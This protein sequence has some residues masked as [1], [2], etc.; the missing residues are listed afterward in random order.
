MQVLEVSPVT[1]RSV[2]GSRPRSKSHSFRLDR[3]IQ[4]KLKLRKA[5]DLKSESRA[6]EGARPASFRLRLGLMLAPES[7]GNRNDRSLAF[8]ALFGSLRACARARN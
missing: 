3:S 7:V 8:A 1:L 4:A 6:H 5:A 2:W